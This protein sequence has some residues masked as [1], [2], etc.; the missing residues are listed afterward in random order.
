MQDIVVKDTSCM[1]A[2]LDKA[3]LMKKKKNLVSV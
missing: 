3:L 2:Y 1:Q